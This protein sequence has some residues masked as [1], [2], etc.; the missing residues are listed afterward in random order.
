MSI[1]TSPNIKPNF[2][3]PIELPEYSVKSTEWQSGQSNVVR[4]AFTGL[5]TQ[6][7]LEYQHLDHLKLVE[8]VNFYNSVKGTNTGFLLPIADIEVS[9]GVFEQQTFLKFPDD[10]L[11]SIAN[12]GSTTVWKII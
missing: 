4:E 1:S 5:K 8:I 11:D 6:I 9:P 3:R 2:V 10:I 12:L 7:S